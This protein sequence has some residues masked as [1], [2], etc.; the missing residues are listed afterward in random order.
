MASLGSSGIQRH[1]L[2]VPVERY[3]VVRFIEV[4]QVLK[5]LEL[6]GPVSLR[7]KETKS[8]LIFGVGF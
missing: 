6:D 2:R 1:P 7:V 3:P 8:D 4:V 5:G